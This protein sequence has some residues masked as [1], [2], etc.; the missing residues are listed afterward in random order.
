MD[1]GGAIYCSHRIPSLLDLPN[2]YAYVG[3]GF[4][5]GRIFGLAVVRSPWA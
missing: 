3:A 1:Q 5:F 4:S 2:A